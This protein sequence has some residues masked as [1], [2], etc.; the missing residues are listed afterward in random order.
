MITLNSIKLNNLNIFKNVAESRAVAQKPLLN[1]P[2]KGTQLNNDV[3]EYSSKNDSKKIIES[4]P[5]ISGEEND[6]LDEDTLFPEL[7][8]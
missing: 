8:F 6:D 3:F 5:D 7:F 1:I 4:E 2:F